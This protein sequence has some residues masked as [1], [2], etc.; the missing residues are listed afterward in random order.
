M[1]ES[2]DYF[3]FKGAIAEIRKEMFDVRSKTVQ[4][5]ADN[6]YKEIKLNM[7]KGTYPAYCERSTRDLLNLLDKTLSLVEILSIELEAVKWLN[8]ASD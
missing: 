2:Q 6:I 7:S 5:K 3:D 8:K 4:R 1:S